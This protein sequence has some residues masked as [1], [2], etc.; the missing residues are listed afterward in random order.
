MNREEKSKLTLKQMS[1]PTQ[2]HSGEFTIY[3]WKCKRS[4]GVIGWVLISQTNEDDR[5]DYWVTDDGFFLIPGRTVAVNL[6]S[7]GPTVFESSES[8]AA[9]GAARMEAMLTAIS[10]WESHP[11]LHIQKE[12]TTP[13]SI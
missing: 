5:C 4:D 6:Y 7:G 1:V 11:N 10:M 13:Q 8:P 12:G 9:P 2:T 3:G